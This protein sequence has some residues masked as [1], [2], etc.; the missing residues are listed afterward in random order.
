[1]KRCKELGIS[2]DR[3]RSGRSRTALSNKIKSVKKRI[4]GF[5]KFVED[6]HVGTGVASTRQI[7]S[8]FFT[9]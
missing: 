6:M 4:K 8:Y 7:L 9:R 2:E 3:P 5:E 1:M